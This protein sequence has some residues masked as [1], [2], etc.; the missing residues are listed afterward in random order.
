VIGSD[1]I[2]SF[3]RLR[4]RRRD[5]NVVLY[6]F[7]LAKRLPSRESRIPTIIREFC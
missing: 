4:Y 7:D 2:P 3:D 1:G 5:G 6:A